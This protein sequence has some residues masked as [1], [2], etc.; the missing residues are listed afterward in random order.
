M[1]NEFHGESGDESDDERELMVRQKDNDSERF[2]KGEYGE[3][4]HR[5]DEPCED[6]PDRGILRFDVKRGSG[7]ADLC[8]DCEWP[9]WVVELREE[10]EQEREETKELMADGGQVVEDED[11]T[12]HWGQPVKHYD[13]REIGAGEKCQCQRCES[14]HIALV[15][16]TRNTSA[17]N[18]E[19]FYCCEGCGAEGSLRVEGMDRTWTGAIDYPEVFA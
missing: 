18:W 3:F 11:D 7:S 14:R 2:L 1:G 17:T 15:S 13:D 10:K 19:E 16:A 4:I 6:A 9:D 12:D 8:P 5:D